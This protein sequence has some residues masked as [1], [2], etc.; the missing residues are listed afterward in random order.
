MRKCS[1]FLFAL[2]CGFRVVG[3]ISISVF[4]AAYAE[5]FNT[6]A[7]TG[8]SSAVPAGWA[9]SESGTN[10]ETTYAAGTGSN[11]AGNTY[12]FGYTSSAERAFGGLQSGSL[13][14]TIGA[15]Y[16]NNTGSAITSLAISYTGEQWRLG[17]LGRAD[18][19]DFQY[20]TDAT[21]LTTGTWTDFDA[22]DFTAPVTTGTTGA[23][24]GNNAANRTALSELITGLNISNGSTFWIRWSDFNASGAD[25]GLGIDDF[26]ITAPAESPLPVRFSNVKAYQYGSA[27]KIEWSNLTETDITK[28]L[29]E[30]S[31]NGIS[32]SSIS[33]TTASA[34]DGSRADYSILDAS[35]L[36]GAN[37]YRIHAVEAGGKSLYSAIVKVDTRAGHATAIFIFPNP[38]TG[39]QLSLQTTGFSKG[40]YRI[41]VFNENGQQVMSLLQHH[42][43]GSATDVIR[44]PAALSAGKYTLV[45]SADGLK[46]PKPF[47]LR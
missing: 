15:A 26:S 1:F 35:P 24:D 21:S 28:Y 32:F 9:F 14:P 12:S 22:L 33:A 41:Q 46:L 40:S 37:L 7:S 5:D 18:H 30:R 31:S 38:V 23:L 20:S 11:N 44:L 8:T 2:L 13:N 17:A 47:I 4:G 16:T 34:N 10:A 39:R 19:L 42:Q 25:D 43:G 27:V 36:P 45:V 6:L 29:V 3:Q